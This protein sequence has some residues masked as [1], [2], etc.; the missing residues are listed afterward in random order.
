MLAITFIGKSCVG[1]TKIINR[2]I[3]NN[4]IILLSATEKKHL[5][6]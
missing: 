3:T 2:L 4:D 6:F 5:L 1:K